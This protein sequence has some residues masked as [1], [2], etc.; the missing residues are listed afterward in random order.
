MQ[1]DVCKV[2]CH[3]KIGCV[4]NL[5]ISNTYEWPYLVAKV[6]FTALWPTCRVLAAEARE[7]AS[8]PADYKASQ[9]FRCIFAYAVI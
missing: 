4:D 6:W 7:K 9:Y 1:K 3:V 2:K 5:T 8:P